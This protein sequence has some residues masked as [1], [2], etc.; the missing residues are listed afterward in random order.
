M[1]SGVVCRGVRL[2]CRV[3][4]YLDLT[5]GGNVHLRLKHLPWCQALDVTAVYI[6]SPTH[7]LCYSSRPAEERGEG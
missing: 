2:V 5:L 1:Q 6:R 3:L 4:V 7:K